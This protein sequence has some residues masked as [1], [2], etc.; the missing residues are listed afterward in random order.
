LATAREDRAE[1]QGPPWPLTRGEV[2]AFADDGL[3]M[4]QLERIDSGAW[5]RAELSRRPD[6]HE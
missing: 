2:E 1:V 3:V 5:W 6:R 4:R